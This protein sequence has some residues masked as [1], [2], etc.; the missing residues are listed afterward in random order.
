MA[1]APKVAV[2]SAIDSTKNTHIEGFELLP[3]IWLT[4]IPKTP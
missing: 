2:V 3:E 1:Q 4:F